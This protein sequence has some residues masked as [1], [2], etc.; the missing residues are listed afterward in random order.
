VQS[1]LLFGEI[2]ILTTK[3]CINSTLKPRFFGQIKQKSERVIRDAV[4]GIIQ[5]ESRTF[6]GHP[7]TPLG[8][9]REKIPQMHRPDFLEMTLKSLPYRRLG[10]NYLS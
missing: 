9:G 2:N 1:R 4:F 10:S 5:V 3:H 6:S 8:I 7:L